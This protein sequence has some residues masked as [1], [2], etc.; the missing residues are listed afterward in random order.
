[1]PLS[2]LRAMQKG[3]K[4]GSLEMRRN[5]AVEAASTGWFMHLKCVFL[6]FGVR[7]SSAGTVLHRWS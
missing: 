6:V 3:E 1:M 7:S 4:E 5:V 2:E